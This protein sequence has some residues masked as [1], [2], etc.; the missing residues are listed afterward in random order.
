MTEPTIETPAPNGIDLRALLR[1]RTEQKIRRIH[2]QWF[3]LDPRIQAELDVAEAQLADLVGNE[4]R[5]QQLHQQPVKKYAAPTAVRVAQ[6]RYNELKAQS[7]QVGVMGVF[8]N[9]TENQLNE[10]LA[11]KDSFEKAK[12]I[13][14]AAWLR[15]EDADGNTIPDDQLGRDDLD[16]LMQPEVLEQGEWLPLATKIV[17]G[18]TSA[19]DRPTSPA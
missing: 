16:T 3:C 9:L 11:V 15:W 1:E 6:D 10:V 18:S 8:Q 12:A 7:R 13:L 2:R 5:K 14:A 19:P 17:N 4:I